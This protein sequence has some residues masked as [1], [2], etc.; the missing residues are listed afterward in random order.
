V[1]PVF[2]IFPPDTWSALG[3]DRFSRHCRAH[4][5]VLGRHHPPAGRCDRQCA[6]TSLLAAVESMVPSTGLQGLSFL[7][8]P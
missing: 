7:R 6:N 2:G 4:P 3:H 8:M 1:K 5:L